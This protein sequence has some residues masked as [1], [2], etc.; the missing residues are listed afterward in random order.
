MV[1]QK[2]IFWSNL[3]GDAETLVE[4]RF[5]RVSDIASAMVGDR[6]PGC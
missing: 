5:L 1:S 3:C 6:S 2:P 4:A